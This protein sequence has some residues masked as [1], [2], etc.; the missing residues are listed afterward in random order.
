MPIDAGAVCFSPAPRLHAWNF[1]SIITVALSAAWSYVRT[2]MGMAGCRDFPP[3]HQS[4]IF[5]LPEHEEEAASTAGD[6]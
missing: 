4:F 3:D 1:R 5:S 2:C 6:V